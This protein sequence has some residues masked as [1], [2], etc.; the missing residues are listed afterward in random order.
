MFGTVV[1]LKDEMRF[2]CFGVEKVIIKCSRCGLVQLIPQ[3]TERELDCLYSA[4]W[5]KEDFKG[6]K[7]KVKIAKYLPKYLRRGDCILEV[8]NGWGDNIKYLRGKGY[9]VVGIDK[10]Q[11]LKG[12]IKADV[13]SYKA[14]RKFDFIYS[15]HFLEHLPD[16]LRFIRWMEDNLAEGGRWLI[17][18]PSLNNPLL[19]L[20]S[21]RKF[22]WYPYH[23]FF[24]SK[25]T[26]QMMLPD[27]KAKL[28]QEYGIINHLRWLLRGKPGN[29]NPHIPLIDD[30]Y[31]WIIT[32]K[33]YGD[34]LIVTGNV[35]TR[36]ILS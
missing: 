10:D 31:K 33:G 11:Q 28:V 32:K 3:W 25:S 21:F 24:F 27:A 8:G 29:W 22:Y 13:F 14:D 4:Y 34:T 35:K 9:W 12:E 20:K 6:Q 19:K 30:I 5:K 2:R 17:E 16:P 15:L 18:I 36:E 23:L 26:I 1:A 7:R